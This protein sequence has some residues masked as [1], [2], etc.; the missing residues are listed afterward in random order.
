MY[1]GAFSWSK[2]YLLPWYDAN[3]N[4][5][6]EW[7]NSIN[8]LACGIKC[9]W[10][11]TTVSPGYL[12]ELLQSANGLEWLIR[13]EINKATGI[14][15]GIDTDVWNPS[16]DLLLSHRLKEDFNEF[17][18][19]NKYILMQRFNLRQDLPLITFIGRLVNEKGAD[20]IPEAIAKYLY[21]GGRASFVVLGT[22]D[23]A[24][25]DKFVHMKQQFV[26][27]FD[28]SLEYNE[29]L[30]HQLYAG[31]DF[32][33]MPSRVEPCGLNQLYAFKYGTIPIVRTTGGLADTVID[34]SSGNGTGLRFD[35]FSVEALAGAFKRAALLY[36]RKE[37]LWELIEKIMDLDYSW[38][39]SAQKYLDVYN[40]ITSKNQ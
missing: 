24:L 38:Q 9:C 13:N 34:F 35:D 3:V 7:G 4:G 39:K 16:T 12:M 1:H 28:T 21:D 5:L 26:S 20:L 37:L 11:F 22:G 15:N 31:S 17:K 40:K 18:R 33:M 32:L 19:E 36:E 27:F 30:S 23:P 2:A 25:K 8:P 14:I 6:L 10:Q 29:T